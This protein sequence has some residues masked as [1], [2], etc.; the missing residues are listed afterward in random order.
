MASELL[1]PL[2]Q[3]RNV[4]KVGNGQYFCRDC[5]IEFALS[6]KG[7]RLYR[8]EADGELSRIDESEYEE[9]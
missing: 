5:F 6:A 4:G 8:V 7:L 2:C 3:G 9:A 1:C